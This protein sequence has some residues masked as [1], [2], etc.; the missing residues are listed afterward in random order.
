[1]KAALL[2]VLLL[3]APW[4]IGAPLREDTA[5]LEGMI[6]ARGTGVPVAQARAL[7]TRVSSMDPGEALSAMTD[8]SGKFRI[9]RIPPGAYRLFVGNFAYVPAEYG[10]R[11][12]SQPG[13]PIILREG[14]SFTVDME[15]T[16]AATIE[17]KVVNEAG[18]PVPKYLV[19]A[20][21][22]RYE[23]GDRL[24]TGGEYAVTEE[25]GRFRL[26]GLTPGWYFISAAPPDEYGPLP[27]TEG[28]LRWPVYYGG[29]TEDSA[30]PVHL[31]PGMVFN[32]GTLVAEQ[33][34]PVR[35]RGQVINAQTGKPDPEARILL[36]KKRRAGVET[37]GLS[38]VTLNTGFFE[39][40]GAVPGSYVVEAV[41]PFLAGESAFEVQNANIDN[42]KVLL[43]SRVHVTGRARVDPAVDP[44]AISL[45]GIRVAIEAGRATIEAALDSR[46]GFILA[47]VPAG[48][49]RLSLSGAPA[50][51]FL[52]SAR[53]GGVDVLHQRLPVGGRL[54]GALDIAI[55]M[56]S[57]AFVP[58]TLDAERR[59]VPGSVVVLVPDD[60]TRFDLYR[61]A[62]TDTAGNAR[63][64][65]V[66]P[67]EYRAFC[68]EEIEENAWL[69]PD[70]LAFYE[71]S[72]TPVTL[73]ESGVVIATVSVNRLWPAPMTAPSGFEAPETAPQN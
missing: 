62:I 32:A 2:A 24:F 46:G 44:S 25:N 4:S 47:N 3:L 67:G 43:H 59:P 17:G 20:F 15:L 48:E 42:L 16:P 12:S 7:L 39:L 73:H 30:R 23:R 1:M 72:G 54:G 70:I 69:D 52:K 19:K 37:T 10:Q 8:E 5:L 40:A 21:R 13:T 36:G 57:S 45:E 64:E 14:D 55:G 41:T 71:R 29:K 22:A 18:D 31:D 27:L 6:V 35:V 58:I 28:I 11:H 53:L 61:S 56:S 68:W 66:V 51:A 9:D 33:G 49:Y 60:R 38:T 34:P 50:G 65:H 26:F 63:F